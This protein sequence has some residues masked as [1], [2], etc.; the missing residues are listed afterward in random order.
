[1]RRLWNQLNYR[2]R[3]RVYLRTLPAFLLAL[4][5]VSVFSWSMFTGQVTRTMLQYQIQE[6]DTHLERLAARA[7]SEAMSLEARKPEF[8]ELVPSRTGQDAAAAFTTLGD[9]GPTTDLVAGLALLESRGPRTG[10]PLVI[11]FAE[12]D[13]AVQTAN[14]SHL[15][16][17]LRDNRFHFRPSERLMR[18]AGDRESASPLEI[19]GYRWHRVALFPPLMVQHRIAPVED[20]AQVMYRSLLPV[21]VQE[22]G[23]PG[24]GGRNHGDAR[25]AADR[26]PGLDAVY[27]LDLQEL[28]ESA[29]PDQWWCVLDSQRRFLAGSEVTL[30]VGQVLGEESGHWERALQDG[31]TGAALKA[32]LGGETGLHLDSRGLKAGSWLICAGSGKYPFITLVGRP[33]AG[34]QGLI[35]RYT[36]MGLAVGV[37]ALVLAL[38]G[39]TRVINEV[40]RRL[41]DLGA[42]MDRVAGGDLGCRLPEDLQGELGDL[43]G[44]FNGMAEHLQET[45]KVARKNEA[46]L[47][48]SLSNLRLLDKAKQDFLVLISHEVRTPLT[49]I[50]GGV[51]YLKSTLKGLG[52]QEEQVLAQLNLKEILTII[53]N[54]GLRLRGFMNDAIL[55]TSIQS[56]SH[57]L[58]RKPVAVRDLAARVIDSLGMKIKARGIRLRNELATRGDWSLFGES[59]V[60]RVV[61]TKLLDNAVIHN[62][63]GGEVVIREVDRI[64][65]Q[66]T[67]E[68][69]AA[70]LEEATAA[71]QEEG[72]GLEVTW[73]LL[74]IHNT[75]RPI[76]REKRAALFK[77]FE[78]VGPIENHQRGTGLSLPIAQAAMQ[79]NGGSIFCHAPAEGGN[80]FYLL[81][82]TV[83]S[84]HFAALN[85]RTNLWDDQ[86]Q[87]VGRRTGN[88]KIGKMGDP[89]GLEV[90]LDHGG[91]GTPGDVHQAGGGVDRPRRAHDEEEVTAGGRL[92]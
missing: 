46:R 8:R 75:G 51:D 44:Y 69:L 11:G 21:L 6:L 79:K 27:F 71:L 30:P 91:S 10:W 48:V 83:D 1:M 49:A 5:A 66:G 70:S 89:A 39:L 47:Q 36:L 65:G 37:V 80:S 23:R 35:S 58:D 74:E 42:G 84:A 53:E 86:G 59:E 40:T 17:W 13:S 18:N 85:R 60:L 7:A 76:P 50:M 16:T 63:D 25:G 22:R 32:W 20:G 73:R 24:Q 88:E 3:N 68:E 55:M 62:V 29:A 19:E 33:A 54:N 2:I 31:K 15:Q 28:L 57:R 41:G 61:L 64:P 78:L 38:L 43:F 77:Q 14:Q 4:G 87:G 72:D 67:V 34:L 26:G 12:G 56:A 90:E 81:M 52:P 45:H 9:D 82:P 92:F